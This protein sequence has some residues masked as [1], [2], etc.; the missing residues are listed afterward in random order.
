MEKLLIAVHSDMFADALTAALHKDYD[1]RTCTDG[2]DA[3]EL[4][5]TFQ[6]DALILYLR[7]PR[8]DG[9]TLL[10]QSAHTPKIIIGILD[11]TNPYIEQQAPK[12]GIGHLMITPTVNTITTQLTQMRIAYEAPPRDPQLETILH[13]HTLS[14]DVNLT[15]WNMLRVGIPLFAADPKLTLSKEL[16]P[17]IAIAVDATD[18]RAVE[19]AIRD[20][21]TKA[22]N[23]RNHFVWLK[24]FP[25]DKNGNIPC[26]NNSLFIK[27]LARM[28][29][30]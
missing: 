11:T 6:P 13:L 28:I 27:T 29:V 9:L 17:A 30:D 20:C 19:H 24:Y 10:S 1:I 5:N 25:P 16:Y 7:L 12:V 14:M 21:I 4:L 18:G 8:T 23:R 22:W 2:M 3:L 26:P 15:G